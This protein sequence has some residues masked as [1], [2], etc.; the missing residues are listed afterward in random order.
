MCFCAENSLSITR[1]TTPSRSI[2]NVTRRGGIHPLRDPPEAR[3]AERLRDAA[4]RVGQEREVQPVVGDEL[5]VRVGAVVAD[6][7]HLAARRGDLARVVAEAARLLGARRRVVLRVEVED[8]RL[9]AAEIREADALP[10]GGGSH[11]VRRAVTLVDHGR[12]LSRFAARAK[13][14]AGRRRSTLSGAIPGIALH[15]ADHGRRLERLLAGDDEGE[16]DERPDVP[17]PSDADGDGRQPE[18]RRPEPAGEAERLGGI[19]ER[20]PDVVQRCST[21][22]TRGARC[23]RRSRAVR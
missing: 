4:V 19:R 11:E 8:E 5:L 16:A 14:A 13:L 20:A 10:V 15:G 21:R 12:A 3:D 1:R 7:D 18:D 6:A 23:R 9:S 2:T 22:S 17:E